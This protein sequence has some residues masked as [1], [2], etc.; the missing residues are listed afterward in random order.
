MATEMMG[1]S[2]REGAKCLGSQELKRGPRCPALFLG[3]GSV[4]QAFKVKLVFVDGTQF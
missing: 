3:L 4:T 2:L 1:R